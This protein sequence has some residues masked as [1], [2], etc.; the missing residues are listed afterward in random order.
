MP[1]S[2]RVL[3]QALA[4]APLFPTAF[5]RAETSAPPFQVGHLPAPQRIRR[6][7]SAGPPADL[8]LMA[9]VPEKMV[10]F[11]SLDL[12]QEAASFLPEALRKMPKYGRL[13]GRASSLSLE[14]LVALRPDL[15]VDTGN[16]DAAWI[17]AARRI[18][19]QTQIPWL[20]FDGRLIQSPHQLLNAGALLGAAPR[21]QRQAALAQR[22]IDQAQAFADT[23][24]AAIRFY[25]ARGP[26]GLETGLKG[27]IHT[28]AAELLGL[29][30]VVEM[31]GRH[32]LTTVSLENLLAW[33]PD[34]VLVQDAVTY[35]TLLSDPAWQGVEAVAQ[36]RILFLSGLPFGWL[37]APPGLNRLLGLRRLHA[38][39]DPA[40]RSAFRQDM[41]DYS[42]LFW[43]T[44]LSAA[45]YQQ[46]T[47]TAPL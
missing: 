2:R 28:E 33:Q 20:L 22:F 11:S 37:D 42:E 24:A 12:G 31:P 30:N 46:L 27:S 35:Q 45:Q 32:G 34:I 19:T 10:G 39:L 38:W 1:I 25:A 26:R 23:P 47:R 14:R 29:R 16:M 8:L 18:S 17:S 13:A 3:L 6:I 9:L 4:T 5:C 41:H 7:V 43:H 15:I 40:V 44:T 21:A 36:R